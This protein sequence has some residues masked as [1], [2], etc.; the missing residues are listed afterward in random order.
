METFAKG[1]IVTFEF[2]YTNLKKRKLR[3]CLVLSNPMQDDILLCQIKSNN[4]RNRYC[5]PLPLDATKYQALQKDSLIRCNMLFTADTH[6]I[7]QSIDV[8]DKRTYEEVIQTILKIIR[9]E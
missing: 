7:N 1:S 3:P 6:Q 2:P 5:V 4:K 8:I 9:L